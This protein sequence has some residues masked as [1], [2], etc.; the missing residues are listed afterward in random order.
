MTLPLALTS[1]LQR[2]CPGD[3]T[4]LNHNY[5]IS[6]FSLVLWDGRGGLELLQLLLA[7]QEVLLQLM[8]HVLLQLQ[9]ILAGLVQLLHL[10][11][12]ALHLRVLGQGRQA[13]P[14]SQEPWWLHS[15]LRQGLRG[16]YPV[17]S[18]LNFIP[19]EAP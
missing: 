3:L 11:K 5:L 2:K 13:P 4:S 6:T 8:V 17:L 16:L 1:F 19:L 12:L 18:S 10:L 15:P 14:S 9:L 7:E